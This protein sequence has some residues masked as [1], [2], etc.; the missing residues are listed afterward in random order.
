MLRKILAVIVSY[1]V[2]AASAVLL[3]NLTGE[4]PHADT[5]INFKIITAVYGIFFSVLSGLIL[6]LIARTKNLTLNFI[7]AFI[8]A[9]FAAVSLLTSDGS[10]WTQ[11]FAIII[12][13]PASLLGGIIYL[14]R[15]S[16]R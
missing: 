9:A 14:K 16:A 4:K 7:L 5:T 11:L 6:Q 10:H 15:K 12:F 8:M 1:V 13:A 3:F 2:F